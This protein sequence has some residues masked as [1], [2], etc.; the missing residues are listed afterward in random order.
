MLLVTVGLSVTC[1][2]VFGL[3]PAIQS[4][5]PEWWRRSR[6]WRVNAPRP[7]PQL[8]PRLNLTEA[9]VVTQISLLMLL[10]VGAGLFARTLSNLQPIP[11]GFNPENV[12]L[13]EINAPQAGYPDDHAAT[14]YAELRDR[15]AEIPGVRAAT[16]RMRR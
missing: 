2:V 16:C 10:L 6:A 1:G 8:E 9:L 4:T 14:Y 7:A 15:F 5:R 12:L 13:F 11:L 3:A